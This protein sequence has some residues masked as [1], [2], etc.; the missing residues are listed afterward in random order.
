M[1]P[2]PAVEGRVRRVR[3]DVGT[4]EWVGAG[5]EDADLDSPA[6]PAGDPDREG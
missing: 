1:W 2:T 5:G 6:S 3:G 4:E